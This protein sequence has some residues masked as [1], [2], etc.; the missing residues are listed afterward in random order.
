M[1]TKHI[2]IVSNTLSINNRQVQQTA[3][4]LKAGG[5]VPFISRYRKEAT[6]G[7]DE[8][9]INDIKEQLAK[10]V[11]VDKRRD[12]ILKTIEEQ[13]KLSPELKQQLEKTY[14]LTELE[15]L[16]LPYKQKRKTK[17]SVARE[18]GLEGLAKIIM[19]QAEQNVE[20]R[21]STFVK[22]EVSDVD[23]AISGALDIIAEWVSESKS[24]RDRVR[25][26]FEREANITSK[27][28]K[29]KEEEGEKYKDYFKFEEPLKRCRSHR[30]LAI[31]RAEED[32]V[33]RVNIGPSEEKA[34]D[35]LNRIFVKGHSDSSYV[36]DAVK[37]SYKRLLK[38]SIET[39]FKNIAKER[40]DKEAIDVFAENLKQ[41]LLQ[42][43]LGQ[44]R[45]LAID[46]G[47][48]TGCKVVC[49]DAQGN[50][51]HNETI[52]P[53]AP[54]KQTGPSISKIKTLVNAYKIEAIAIG[55]G[56]A[57]RETE[58]FI[59]KIAFEKPIQV[60]VVN[61]AGASIYSASSIAREEFP[62]YDVTVRG[63]VSIGRRLMD[64][65]AELVKID[66]KSVGVGQYQHDVDQK[67]LKESLDRVVES[68]VNRVGVDLNTASK[69]LLTYVS[70]LG[71][72]L[73]QN[74][75]EYRKE[76]GAFASR[77][78]LKKVPRMGGK[79]FEQCAGFM[80]IRDGKQ[81]LDN[82]AVH[83]ESYH[84]VKRMAKDIKCSVEELAGNKELC[85]QVDINKYV[86]EEVGLPT[87][88]DILSE[89][90]KPGRDPRQKAKVFEFAKG[91]HK[92]EDLELGMVLPGLVSNITNFGAFVD[93]GVKQDGLVHISNLANEFISNPADYV[94]L[95]QH[96]QV[97]V[98]DLDIPRKRIGLSMKDAE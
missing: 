89:L 91:I 49:L 59:K 51:E 11:E 81:V 2:E 48:R 6:G 46:P 54:K 28:V 12:S 42:A 55:N 37:D 77:E 47:F 39:E 8:V 1:Q 92:M 60:F 14:V 53:H 3:E 23:E 65:L 10:L 34:L 90:E 78:A 16:Y 79:A 32:G 57:G 84:I 85:Q 98:I 63:S 56:T 29:G 4:L 13:G 26:L 61:E 22:G 94:Q 83:P 67:M 80:R 24:A 82:S 25:W 74:V 62:Q 87:L 9:Q 52:F 72:Q 76:N 95:N 73:A 68:C 7:L 40:A 31:R 71:P 43:P 20:M 93:V 58:Y 33:L 18:K 96:V 30:Y 69:H 19:K 86:T 15:D 75:V 45:T 50:L 70:G 88:T 38:P 17:A 27:L 66:P 41:L 44:K 5:T 97:K 35:A 21:A 64:P 36:A